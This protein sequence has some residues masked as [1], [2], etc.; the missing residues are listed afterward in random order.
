MLTQS[1]II[2]ASKK[3]ARGAG[4]AWGMAEEAAWACNNLFKAG[5]DGF[6]PLLEILEA[7]D[8]QKHPFALGEDGP[9]C[10]LTLGVYFLDSRQSSN[11]APND[12]I[13][14][15]VFLSILGAIDTASDP[16]HP[17]NIVP[18]KLLAFA[19]RTYVPE[20]AESRL[21]GAGEG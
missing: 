13:G 3:A 18:D 11:D 5:H 14:K 4:F 19:A 7:A 21:R 15:Q 12:V 8:G 6:T 16:C 1:E 2:A 20:T 9:K 17:P 10:G